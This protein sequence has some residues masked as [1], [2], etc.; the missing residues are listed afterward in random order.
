[1]TAAIAE[2]E[3]IFRGLNRTPGKLRL[4]ASGL[5]WKSSEKS[6]DSPNVMT[7]GKEDFKWAQWIKVARG[8][9]IRIG[10]SRD[11]PEI[12]V[13]DRRR[14][15]FDGF[16]TDDHDKLANLFKQYFHVTLE[17]KDMSLRGWNWGKVDVQASDLAFMVAGKPAFEVP[18]AY[19]HNASI[20]KTEVAIEFLDPTAFQPKADGPS[21]SSKSSARK[22]IAD[23]MVELRLYVPG[24]ASSN[25]AAEGST[26]AGSDQDD[27]GDGDG[28]TAAQ[29][30]HDLVMEKAEIG[31]V[32][33][34]GIVTFPDVLCTTPR[35]R[36]DVDMYSD[37]LRLRG[38]TYDYKVL[39][40]SIQRLFLLPKPDDIHF[41][42]VVQLDPPIRQGQT[43]YPFL[44][45][46]F[47]KDEEMDAELNLDEDT[48]SST[49]QQ[50]HNKVEGQA[51]EVVSIIF[52]GL[53]KKK[54]IFPQNFTS[55][56]GQTAI[57]CSIKTNEGLVYFLD[58]Y[59]LFISKQPVLVA[60]S[61]LH[62]VKFA[63]VGGALQSGRTFDLVLKKK[64]DIDLQLSS[65]SREEHQAIDDYFKDKG[66]KVLNEMNDDAMVA[67]GVALSDDE[68]EQMDDASDADSRSREKRAAAGGAND[69]D[70]ESDDESFKGD[71]DDSDVAEEF[72]SNYGGSDSDSDE[73]ETPAKKK[74]PADS[75]EPPA[76]K[77]K[78]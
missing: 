33:G 39:Y 56:T 32:Q 21:G 5:G 76:K 13:G 36:Y 17:T 67:V 3:N 19:V 48:L 42:F 26:N 54:I 12:K 45:M 57:K 30:L 72:D 77:Q 28:M 62:S 46:Q 64:D 2:F 66:K 44:V 53:A 59:I 74:P 71:E 55:A 34:E 61:D 37:F 65:L 58:K 52:K 43:R 40:S 10:L 22:G 23:Q 29:V 63:R 27:T 8:Y 51:H 50:E 7:V 78:K 14:V 24:N 73:E 16:R 38:K 25:A 20:N 75:D 1:M 18:L 70:D 6:S 69:E 47:A 15:T 31:R 11:L 49:F 9:Q 4:A 41:N 60:L 68:D 35:G